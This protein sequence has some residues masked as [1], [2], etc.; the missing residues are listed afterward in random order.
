[1]T[2]R[3]RLAATAALAAACATNP[4]TGRRQ[5]SLIS[6]NREIQM[7]REYDPQIAA[8]MG[9]DP[10]TALQRYVHELGTR[11]A[12]RSERPSLPWTF[13][14]V[15]DPVV[16]AF[17]L[18][19]GFIYVTRGIL[20]HFNS[21]AELAA[22]L[23]HEIGHVTARHSASQ[24]S[25]QQ[26]A[27]VGLALGSIVSS[28]VE[29]FSGLAGAA[30]GVLFLKHSRDDEREA[31]DLG[32]RY[33]RRADYDAR[34]MPD[35]FTMLERVS[36]AQPGGRAPEWLAT[37]PNPENRRARITQQIAALPPESLGRRVNRDAY[38]RRID[39]L[40]FGDNPRDGFFRGAEFLHPELR[41]RLRFPDGWAT[42]NQRQAV[43]AVSP[44]KDGMVQVSLATQPSA[45]AAA[46]AFFDQA[47]VTGGVPTR[48][49]INGLRAVSASFSAAA[50]DG[51]L[52]GVAAFVEHGGR[53]FQLFA[54]A[55]DWGKHGAA[56][57]RAVRSFA[58]LTERAA[59]DV[60]PWRIAVVN[61]DDAATLEEFARRRPPPAPVSVA[62]L[63]LINQ[64]EP[65]ARLTAGTR[66]K[67]VV[68]QPRP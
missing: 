43:V 9:L 42:Q 50:V 45:E 39:G 5:L 12:A 60:Q 29:R 22:V 25:R 66:L 35:V 58:V 68:G 3:I 2:P 8:S 63:A 24:L 6:E 53:V 56:A 49:S 16:N 37:H 20:A 67:W 10:D 44:G 13:R 62:T 27:Q 48:E 30:L 32:L 38:L 41:F 1:M 4:A 19:G 59:L 21:E 55:V 18:P 15:D 36:A 33:M 17:A 46:R 65:G 52:R 47:G 23:G 54:L 64:M 51:E 28:D 26:L 31:D 40:V 7:G 57:E 61:A 34:E 14:V 11:L